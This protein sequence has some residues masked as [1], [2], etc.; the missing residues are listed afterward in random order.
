VYISLFACENNHYLCTGTTRQAEITRNRLRRV[1]RLLCAAGE[2][3][4]L[5]GMLAL[6][7]VPRRLVHKLTTHTS[8]RVPSYAAG[9]VRHFT[10]KTRASLSARSGGRSGFLNWVCVRGIR[11]KVWCVLTG[12]IPVARR[13]RVGRAEGRCLAAW[14]KRGCFCL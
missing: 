9:G 10:G 6:R 12:T 14:R 2:L 13:L 1:C 11:P 7:C 3:L 8:C 4:A 5:D